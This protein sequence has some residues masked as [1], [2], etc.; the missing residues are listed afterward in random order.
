MAEE[1]AYIRHRL[2]EIYAYC[3]AF[4]SLTELLWDE[5]SRVVVHLLD[6][7]T[8]F[9]DLTLDITVCRAA[10]A[11][12][13]RAASA[14]A[15]KT[16][17]TDIVS[18]ILTTKLSTETNLVCFLEELLLELDV[19]EG[20]TGLIAC[21]RECI[22]VVSRSEFNSEQVLLCTGTTDHECDMVRRT[23][24]STEALHLLH[25]EWDE[26]ARILD[27]CFGLLVEVSLVSRT[28][29]LG[30]AEEV[31]LHT[32]ASLKVNLSR[33]VALGIYLVV[34]VERSVL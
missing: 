16:D 22:V 11:K 14:V 34:H 25:E 12:S 32:F 33:E 26:G 13:D 7:D 3:I 1:F 17:H 4:A 27:T 5:G 29:T 6:P 30:H 21:G 31:V 10:Y 15:W 24:C 9:V 19:T 28:T 23:S 8:V 20:T 2:V 18:H